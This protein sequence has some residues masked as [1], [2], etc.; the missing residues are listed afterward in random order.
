M[1]SP[2][3]LMKCGLNEFEVRMLKSVVVE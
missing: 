1:V 2:G 3:D